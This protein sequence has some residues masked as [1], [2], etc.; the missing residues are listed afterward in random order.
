MAARARAQS[1][2]RTK[3]LTL[4]A[5]VLVALSAC[6]NKDLLEAQEGMREELEMLRSRL[7]RLESDT[8]KHSQKIQHL[9]DLEEK[10]V[11]E[12]E[13]G[14]PVP[15]EDLA[16]GRP[17][18]SADHGRGAEAREA[19]GGDDTNLAG[20][21]EVPTDPFAQRVQVALKRAGYDPGPID[22]KAGPMT[23]KAIRAFQR[24]NNL[25]ETGVADKATWDLLKRYLE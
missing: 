14:E 6:K 9:S 3:A 2:W 25:P 23:R 8:A 20:A 24:E 21:P 15:A 12:T 1:G 10:R 18:T 22:A 17:A 13:D 4:L 5:G 16:V 11:N 19:D 7:L